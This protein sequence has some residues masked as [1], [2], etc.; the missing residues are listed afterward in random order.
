MDGKTKERLLAQTLREHAATAIPSDLDPWPAIRGRLRPQRASR[1]RL[2]LPATRLGW[3]V[4]VLAVFLAVSGAAYAV[5]P[6]LT[7]AFQ[8][9]AGLQHIEESNLA[10]QLNLSQTINGWTVSVQRV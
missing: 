6:V 7:R 4:A 9:E 10:K 2:G 8:M 5:V 1:P 3:V